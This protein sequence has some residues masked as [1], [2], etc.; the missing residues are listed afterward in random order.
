MSMSISGS[1]ADN[2]HHHHHHPPPT[3]AVWWPQGCCL[4][5]S[6]TKSEKNRPDTK[7]GDRYSA[8][9][10]ALTRAVCVGES[11]VLATSRAHVSAISSE[12]NWESSNRR[13]V[14]RM[15]GR[16]A[17]AC[18]RIFSNSTRAM[19]ELYCWKQY[20][21]QRARRCCKKI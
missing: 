6:F 8:L 21:H 20:S 4:E 9:R 5:R 7:W 1:S 15:N 11:N 19:R 16:E 3:V 14:E 10:L 17:E 18:N 12:D 2:H 13:V